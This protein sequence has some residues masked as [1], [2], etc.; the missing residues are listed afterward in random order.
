MT[1][2]ERKER[3]DAISKIG[4][5][6]CRVHHGVHTQ[7]QIHHLL[8]IKYRAMGR[9]ANDAHTIGLCVWHHT[10]GDNAI[11]SVHRNP[12]L[13]RQYYGSQEELLEMQDKLI[14]AA[15]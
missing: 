1:Q 11:L 8:G 2:S 3:F 14:E 7:P 12:K 6:I 15:R 10:G 4:C 9:K 13:F 5:L